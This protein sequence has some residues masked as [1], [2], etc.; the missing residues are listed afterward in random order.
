MVPPPGAVV[1]LLPKILLP[2]LI[3]FAPTL[4]KGI[5]TFAIIA[6]EIHDERSA[7]SPPGNI[8]PAL[9]K[10]PLIAPHSFS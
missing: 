3:P 4:N 8:F 7:L 2:K 10:M 5:P 9:E 6:A 1:V